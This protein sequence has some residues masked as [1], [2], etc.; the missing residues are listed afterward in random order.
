MADKIRGGIEGVHHIKA[1]V[2]G[3][4]VLCPEKFAGIIIE[5][6]AL[7]ITHRNARTAYQFVGSIRQVYTIEV[8]CGIFDTVCLA[9]TV[10]GD[11]LGYKTDCSNFGDKIRIRGVEAFQLPRGSVV[12]RFDHII[13]FFICRVIRHGS[14]IATLKSGYDGFVCGYGFTAVV[15]SGP[16]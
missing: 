5:G 7:R 8:S 1:I 12:C 9:G 16:A 10:D 4:E 11:D 2:R 6:H 15:Q 13:H 14:R 3:R